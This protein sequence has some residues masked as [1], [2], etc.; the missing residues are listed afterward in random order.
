M[1]KY[2]ISFFFP[3]YNEEDNVSELI[4]Q[5]EK[6][7]KEYADNWEIII[8]NDGSSDRTRDIVEGI[9]K[10]NSNIR[11]INHDEN[12]GYGAALTSGFENA[13]YDLIFFSDGDLQFNLNEIIQFLE[14]ID[15]FDY[16]IGYR[17]KRQDN[18]IRIFNANLWNLVL[19]ITCGLKVRDIDC[20]FKLFHRSIFDGIKIHSR[21]AFASAEILLKLK[22][23]E[24]NFIEIG[25]NHYPRL[26][27]EQTGGN[28][29]VIFK[30]INEL[31]KYKFGKNK[32]AS[33]K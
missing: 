25:V 10:G 9:M 6:V 7:L 8:V 15:D 19:R 27:G 29:F 18:F 23:G 32:E 33:E 2:N 26:K 20:A 21:G 22:D 14:K 17:I 24:F 31:L 12:Q 30:A 28:P 5:S 1:K 4:T 11:L 13:K 3:C 16:I